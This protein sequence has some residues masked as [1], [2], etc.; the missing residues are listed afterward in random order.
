MG[1]RRSVQPRRGTDTFGPG[2][3]PRRAVAATPAPWR[4]PLAALVLAG[5]IGALGLNT[6]PASAAEPAASNTRTADKH[7]AQP[8]PR[9]AA[10]QHSEAS[11]SSRTT[12]KTTKKSGQQTR[13][14]SPR[15][16]AEGSGNTTATAALAT[17]ATRASGE[18]SSDGASAPLAK[19]SYRISARFG[20]TGNWSRYHTGQDFSAASGT[21]V[22][23]VVSGTVVKGNVG[24]WA[25][26]HV[27]IRAAD[28][29]STL[30]AHLSSTDVKVGQQ[31]TAGQKIGEVGS[32]GR[33]FGSHLHLEYYPAGRTPGDVYRATDPMAYLT[34]LGI[35]M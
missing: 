9:R 1:L 32:T 13:S 28:G 15:R 30:Y 19:G 35:T 34:S 6:V 2:C 31:V 5:G 25:G 4:R 8:G 26:N 14:T 18:A 7:C 3:L 23:A 24:S 10:P 16:A 11:S 21:P 29:S 22:R 27:A 12:K 20:A 33:S 17:T